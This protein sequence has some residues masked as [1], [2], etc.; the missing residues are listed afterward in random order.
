M[1]K[2][3]K[4]GLLKT[5][6]LTRIVDLV[7]ASGWRRSRLLILGYHGISIDDEHLWNPELFMPQEILRR[8]FE[9]INEAGCQVLDLTTAVELL[10]D[11]RLPERSVVITFDDGFYNFYSRAAP[12]LEEFGFPATV[13]LTTY[14]SEYNEP[15]FAIA[16][17]YLLWKGRDHTV[18]LNG[19]IGIDRSFDLADRSQRQQA[20]KAVVEHAAEYSATEKNE[21]L[22]ELSELCGID[23]TKFCEARLFN[24]MNAAEVG[25]VAAKGVRV[26]LH[27]HRHRVPSVE[28]YFQREIDDNRV[29]IECLTGERPNHFCYPSGEHNPIFFPWMEKSGIVSATT[30]EVAMTTKTTN[31]LLMPR[32]IDTCSLSNTEFKAWLS[33]VAAFLP[34]RRMLAR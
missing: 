12:V 27:T 15:V 9:V 20:H 17:D 21:L 22:R 25:A 3:L 14:Y 33:G 1:L 2:K 32:L 19:L 23:Y 8:R 13:Y 28:E 4:Q 24:L 5:A 26:E 11:G 18:N 10:Y 34:Q 6:E 31:P 29:A 7:S 16:A 30:C